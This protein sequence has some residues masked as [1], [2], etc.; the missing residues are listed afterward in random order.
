VRV[1]VLVL[2]G[3]TKAAGQPVTVT[4]LDDPGCPA[5]YPLRTT[6]D[7]DG[8]VKVALPLGTWRFRTGTG[9]ESAAQ[10]YS[11]ASTAAQQQV[12]VTTS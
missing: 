2:S 9:P 5:S 1:N 6:S 8:L 10:T 11:S 12:T 7:A 3:T 4:H